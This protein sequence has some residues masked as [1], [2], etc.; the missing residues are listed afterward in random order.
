MRG[1]AWRRDGR[2]GWRGRGAACSLWRAWRGW[3]TQQPGRGGGGRGREGRAQEGWEESVESDQGR[4][5]LR[6]KPATGQSHLLCGA[7]HSA[8]ISD[9]SGPVPFLSRPADAGPTPSSPSAASVAGR[10]RLA[11]ARVAVRYR[12]GPAVFP[13]VFLPASPACPA[14]S[15]DLHRRPAA[16]KDVIAGALRH[17]K[18]S[19]S[20]GSRGRLCSLFLFCGPLLPPRAEH[21]AVELHWARLRRHAHARAPAGSPPLSLSSAH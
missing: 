15:P 18:P 11:V 14:A 4:I 3:G 5:R 8:H 19:L 16:T 13:P 21:P 9:P 12:P 10:G 2:R 20:G 1:R 17:S 7:H 6:P